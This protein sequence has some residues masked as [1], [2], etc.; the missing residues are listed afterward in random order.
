MSILKYRVGIRGILC[1][2]EHILGYVF[3]IINNHIY[4]KQFKNRL[5]SLGYN[6]AERQPGEDAYIRKWERLSNK[7]EPY[8]Y[9]L[10]LRYIGQNENIV[11]EAVG[12]TFIEPVLNPIRYRAYY[13]DK[14]LYAQYLPKEFLP[15]TIARRINGG[16]ILDSDYSLFVG[17]P[18][19]CIPTYIKA[20]ILKLSVDTDSGKGVTKLFRKGNGWETVDREPFTVIDL[21]KYGNDWILQEAVEQHAFMAR[22]CST[23]VN[24]LRI[25]VYRSP[26]DEL[27]HVVASMMR[28]GKEGAYCDN[29]HAGGAGVGVNPKTGEVNHYAT[30]QYGNRYEKWNSV[31]FTKEKFVIPKWSSILSFACEVARKNHHLRLLALDICLDKE[32]NPKLLEYNCSGYSYW[33]FLYNAVDALGDYTE[34]IIEYCSCHQ[35]EQVKI[36]Y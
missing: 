15:E 27:P 18:F 8:S 20:L 13:S 4:S 34:E 14:N 10:F 30:D 16:K 28:I 5:R 19:L 36:I 33:L 21:E 24:T 3:I 11:P 25:A 12:R 6:S 32:G 35:V 1:L 2:I 31:D 7:V 9:R 26:K 29:G 22:F 23:A 17:D